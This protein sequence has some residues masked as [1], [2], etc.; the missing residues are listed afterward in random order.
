MIL[1]RVRQQSNSVQA[2]LDE[3]RSNAGTEADS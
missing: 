3:A 2:D 1:V